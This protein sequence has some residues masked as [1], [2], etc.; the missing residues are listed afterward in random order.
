MGG[1]GDVVVD[2]LSIRGKRASKFV[3]GRGEDSFSD[4]SREQV[5]PRPFRRLAVQA[6]AVRG[7]ST[8]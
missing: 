3:V 8:P 7:A 1:D 4:P 2:G 5:R 6:W